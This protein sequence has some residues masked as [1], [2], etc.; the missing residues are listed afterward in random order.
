MCAHFTAERFIE[1]SSS[2]LIY[3][4]EDVR[5]VGTV[6]RDGNKVYTMFVDPDLVGRGIGRQLMQY[7]EA[8]A[9]RDGFDHMETGASITAHQFYLKLGYTDVRESET[10]FGLNYIL[11]KPLPPAT[12]PPDHYRTR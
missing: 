10:E 8:L 12:T 9:V 11:R 6:S 4:A 3:V 1:L 7:I 2:R 5:V